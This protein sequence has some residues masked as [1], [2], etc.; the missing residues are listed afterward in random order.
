MQNILF[1]LAAVCFALGAVGAGRLNW[2]NA[3]F[4]LLTIALWLV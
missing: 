1:I 3:G 2:A 4:C